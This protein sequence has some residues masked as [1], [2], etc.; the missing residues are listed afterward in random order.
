MGAAGNWYHCLL[1]FGVSVPP[2]TNQY[3]PGCSRARV[4]GFSLSPVEPP[5]TLKTTV[6]LGSFHMFYEENSP[7][8]FKGAGRNV[9]EGPSQLDPQRQDQP[10]CHLPEE[11]LHAQAR[12]KTISWEGRRGFPANWKGMWSLLVMQRGKQEKQTDK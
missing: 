8:D 3:F 4:L 2:R 11:P 7:E 12:N 6:T 5:Q 1:K 9:S 10:H